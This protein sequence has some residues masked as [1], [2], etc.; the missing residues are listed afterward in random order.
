[1]DL[2]LVGKAPKEQDNIWQVVEINRSNGKR[3]SACTP[4]DQ[5]ERVKY[6]VFPSTA[7]DWVR[8]RGLPQPPT[9]VDGPC[10]GGI[11]EVAGDVAIGSPL[12]AARVK[13]AVPIIG[14]A[15]GPDFRAYKIELAS[16]KEPGKW[17]PIG[18]EHGHQVSNGQLETWDTKGFDGLY[19]LR[20]VVVRNNGNVE[21]NEIPVVV[22]NSPPT[23]KIVH[24]PKDKSY[25]MEDDELVS[26]TA[27]AQDAWEM[28]KVEFYLDGNK[29][30]ESTVAPYSIRW[31]IVMSDVMP[32]FGGEP[33]STTRQITNP[34]GTVTEKLV[35][36][37]ETKVE[38]YTRADGTKGK[39]YVLLSEV[40]PGA[41]LED[42]GIL[43]ETH[44]IFVRAYDRAGNWAES[45]TVRIL[46]GHKPKEK[47]TSEFWPEVAPMVRLDERWRDE[48][49]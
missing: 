48:G 22:D 10:G 35:L 38:E 39:Q 16:E 7:A 15:R 46:V 33:I 26:I 2:F 9:E 29:L 47:K 1:V 24:P 14:N 11:T 45:A 20:L 40:Q 4:A 36:V 43:T 41:I 31:T 30:G 37:N 18:G 12:V 19:T 34:D 27:D 6:Q 13:G 17:I 21:T 44:T 49:G 23:V 32:V 42:T 3:A 8:E 25:I 28:D 5:I